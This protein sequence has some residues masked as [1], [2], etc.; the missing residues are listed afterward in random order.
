LHVMLRFEIE[1][2]MMNGKIETDEI[3]QV[4]NEKFEKYLGIAPPND[5]L[6][7]LQDV[8]WSFG[9][10]GYFPTYTL[11][12]MYSAQFTESMISQIGEL[13]HMVEGGD[14]S[15]LLGWLRKNIHNHGKYYTADELV[16]RITRGPLSENAFISYVKRKYTDIYGITL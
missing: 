10:I 4:W 1:T 2:E 11:G 7:C 5:T 12:N 8:H 6:G 14:L 16:E 15:T 13:D 9:Y 3:P